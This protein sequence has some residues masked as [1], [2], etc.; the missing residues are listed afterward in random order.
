MIDFLSYITERTRDFSGREWVIG[1]INNWLD[2][3]NG[4]R[5]FLL[6]GG[7]GTGKT[8]VAARLVQM[9]LGQADSAH[10][11]CLGKDSLAYFHFCQAG[12]E[13]TLSP[14]TFVQSLSE[15]L[16][17]RYP[18]FLAA[19]EGAG[20]R[21]ISVSTEQNVDNVQAGAQVIGV[22]IRLEIKGGDA[23]PLFDEAV[24]RPLQVVSKKMPLDSIVILVDSL[25]EALAFSD[26]NNITQL[27]KLVNDFP[28][29]VR[30]LLTCR[31]KNDRVF[32]LI[33]PPTLDLI[34]DAPP[35]LD[36]VK[37]Y[38]IARLRAVPEP[39][40]SSASARIAD[41]SNGNFLYAYHVI[42]DLMLR[43]NEI[44]DLEKFDLPDELEDVYRK[45]IEREMASNA[46]R[47]NDV[48][49]PLLGPIVVARG[50][51]LTKTQLIGITDLA[52]DTANDVLKICAQY[53]VGGEAKD[54]PYRIYHQS[55]REFLLEDE[56]Y[57]VYPAER[58]AA[59]ARYLQD[60]CGANWGRCSDEYALRFAPGH[61]ADAATL[62]EIKRDTRTQTLIRL[63]GN[64][65]YRRRFEKRIGDLP[66]LSEHVHRA[67]QVAALSERDDMLPL[68]IK[69][70]K[71]YISFR[72]D[73]VRAESVVALAKEG[74]L[75]Q[76]EMRLPL[77]A[78]VDEDW[79]IAARLILV[80]LSSESNKTAAEQLHNRSI[81]KMP[82]LD[83]LP[84]LRDRLYAALKNQTIYDFEPQEPM[85]L[86]IGQ[87][88][89]N[90]I[91]GQEFDRELLGSVNPSLVTQL[92]MQAE[93]INQRGYAAS[94]DAPILVNM[95]REHGAE[96]TA[97]LDE[98]IQ[99]HADYNYVEYRNRSLWIVLQAVLRHHPD[100][101]WVKQ[102]LQ[103]ILI[104]ALSGGGVDFSEMLPLTG[105]MFF[106]KARNGD[107][108]VLFDNLRAD[109]FNAADAL[110]NRRGANDSWGN[111]KRRLITLM[112]LYSLL[113]SDTQEAQLHLDRILAL[114]GGFAGYQAPA[115]LRLADALIACNVDRTNLLEDTLSL[116]L[117]SAHHI[118]DYHFCARITARCNALIRWHQLSLHGQDLAD[119]IRRLAASPT[120][121]E[122]AT[123]HNIQEAYQHRDDNDPDTLPIDMARQAEAV[124][125]LVE[126]FQFSAVG[127]LRFNPE[128]RLTEKLGVGTLVR[129]P[130]PGFAPLLA[131]HL[132]ARALSDD[133][134]EEERITLI[135]SLVPVAA[136]NPTALD[137]VLSYLLVAAELDD[138]ELLEEVV[139]E[140]GPVIFT[141]VPPSAS[142]T[143]PD[144]ATQLIINPSGKI[145]G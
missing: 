84:L 58:H 116:A 111:H 94:L 46:T 122:F 4:A 52:E 75:E 138:E 114:P 35:E 57:S 51:G 44:V 82:D 38:A 136:H 69:A 43:S 126:V 90:R 117:R 127:F 50:N 118:Q 71:G 66:T 134:I 109:A 26:D 70:A 112:E 91:S 93:M 80:W 108:R 45:F 7:P 72:H 6:T 76:A 103:Q 14:L 128:F 88:L 119:T 113:F 105:A 85:P 142:Q 49:R 9:N 65:K 55:F 54:R 48:Y 130:D 120:D 16:A 60:K 143:G 123:D 100:Q 28:S 34:T 53:L 140:T 101:V 18:E 62:T 106:E 42:N 137:T 32:D 31:S 102:R 63:T 135:R 21:Q 61:W 27:L 29:Q 22:Q 77:F 24:R 64:S 5:I 33:G 132:S 30:F 89:V 139:R 95:A 47:W 19:L 39:A 125:Q 121:A 74:K 20:S 11:S 2:N 37:L 124:E 59:I 97:L 79:Q 96:G 12:T 15:A 56:K 87:E 68:L 25:D 36:E 8:A 40:R 86:E 99:S 17:N 133:T 141:E 73:Y 107:A 115:Q 1:T 13:S 129:V 131:I 23:R 41:K 98:Y 92:G 83:P 10:Y 104:A 3:P 145:D 78:D 67:V 81:K 110:Q 144:A